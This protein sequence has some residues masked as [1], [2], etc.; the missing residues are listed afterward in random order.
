[1][2]AQNTLTTVLKALD[3]LERLEKEEDGL[4][5]AELAKEMDV[6]RATAHGYLAT[7]NEAGYARNQD[8]KYFISYRILGL[9]NRLK[10]RNNLFRAAKVPMRKL[11]LDINALANVGV[12]E[13][14]E[15]VLLHGDG[16]ITSVDVRE[17]PGLRLPLHTHAAGKLILAEM[18]P[19]RREEI[20]SGGLQRVTDDTITEREK[21]ETEL[22]Q[23]LDRG[24]AVDWDEQVQGVGVAARPISVDGEF[25]GTLSI[26]SPT[27][28]VQ[29]EEHRKEMLQRLKEATDEVV[30][31]Y[32]YM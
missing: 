10:Y 2:G 23:I 30:L 15:W 20:L 27:A 18:S 16:D 13:S 11:V 5:P 1:M 4:G 25:L 24:Y 3:I 31:N 17:Y 7:L 8:G 28:R 22:E 32:R 29:E 26:V 9:G 6:T 14:G 19:E 12:E 21:L